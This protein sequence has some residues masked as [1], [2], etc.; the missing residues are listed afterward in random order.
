[1]DN[2]ELSKQTHEFL[3]WLVANKIRSLRLDGYAED[4][5][6]IKTALQAQNELHRKDNGSSWA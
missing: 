3:I 5:G 6:D 1:M 4:S 2:F